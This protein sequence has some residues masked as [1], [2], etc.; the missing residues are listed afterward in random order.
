MQS[1]MQRMRR[2]G[3]ARPSC[4][5]GLERCANPSARACV[6][7]GA[8]RLPHAVLRQGLRKL[9]EA[10]HGGQPA[11]HRGVHYDALQRVRAMSRP[12]AC[13]RYRRFDALHKEAPPEQLSESGLVAQLWLLRCAPERRLLGMSSLRLTR[14]CP[15]R[16]LQDHFG[17]QSCRQLVSEVAARRCV[18]QTAV[19]INC[20]VL[21]SKLSRCANSL[22]CRAASAWLLR[23]VRD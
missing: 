3:C 22:L 11:A 5:A 7:R 4:V 10:R 9:P 15:T 13:W 12:R 8:P 17:V 23:A 6:A 20:S 21:A 2:T 1:Q 14:T 19:L 16:A 18:R